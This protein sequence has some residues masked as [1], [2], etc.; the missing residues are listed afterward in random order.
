M[1]K[2]SCNRNR[3]IHLPTYLM[4]LLPHTLINL[5]VLKF[6]LYKKGLENEKI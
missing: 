3:L 6:D 2:N 4:S 5:K 1:Y